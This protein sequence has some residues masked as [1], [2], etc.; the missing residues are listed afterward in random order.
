MGNRRAAW[1]MIG[2]LIFFVLAPGTVAGLIPFWLTRWQ[3]EG[4]FLGASILRAV[5]VVFVLA[6][7][8]SLVES[9]VRFAVVGLGT[10]APVAAPTRL[11]VS[12]QYRHVRNP[13]YVAVLGIVLGQSLILGSFVL[14]QYAVLLWLLFHAFV[15]LYEERRLAAQFGASYDVYRQHVRRWWPRLKPWEAGC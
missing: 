5:G 1:A 11:V 15:V 13:M 8:V 9:F 3:V 7:L 10:P 2:S 6:G 14:L 4:P 12:G